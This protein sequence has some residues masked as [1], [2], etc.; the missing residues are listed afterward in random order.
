MADV[1]IRISEIVGSGV[2]VTSEDGQ[3]VYL[4]LYDA[5]N[6]GKRVKLSFSGVTRMTTAFLNAAVGQL[7][8]EFSEADIRSKMLPPLDAESWHLVRL[9]LVIDRAK[10]YFSNK[11]KY[12]KLLHAGMGLVEDDYS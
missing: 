10:Q 2:C 5:F 1:T 12:N 4:A 8:G 6:A 9:K 7:Y 11:E 3:R